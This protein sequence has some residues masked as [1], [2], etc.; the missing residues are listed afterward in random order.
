MPS[1]AKYLFCKFYKEM[2]KVNIFRWYRELCPRYEEVLSDK[3]EYSDI[4]LR[5]GPSKISVQ[6]RVTPKLLR[7]MWEGFPLHFDTKHGWGYLI[8]AVSLETIL[9]AE[10]VDDFDLPEQVMVEAVN[11]ATELTFPLR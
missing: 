5:C 1:Y 9:E 6:R 8:P 4:T 10:G 11:G 3:S 2:T 7:M